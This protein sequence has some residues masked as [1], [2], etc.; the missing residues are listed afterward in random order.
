MAFWSAFLN[1]RKARQQ[2]DS[3]LPH[4]PS[5]PNAYLPTDVALGVLGGILC[6]ADKLSRLAHLRSDPAVAQVLGIENVASQSTLS[7]F[8]EAFDESAS[9]RLNSL[10]LWAI[11]RLPSLRPGYTLDLDSW[12]LLH[13]DGHQEGV[14]CGHT[15]RGLKPCHRPL[16]AC[17]AEAKLVAGF[18]LRKGNA[19]CPEQAPKFLEELLDGLPSHIR[20]SCVRADAGFY[21]EKVLQTL[22]QRRLGYVI[23]MRLYPKWQKFCRHRDSEWTPT[24]I[25]GV[26][27]QEIDSGVIG[28]RHV[29]L[30]TSLSRFPDNAGKALLEVPGYKF[31]ALVTNLPA[32]YSPVAVWRHYNGRCDSENRIKELGEQFGVKG[33]CCR[34]F[35][36]TQAICQ[37][38]I[39]AYNLCVLLQRELGLLQKIELQT[40]RW[41]LFC[42]AAVFSNAQGRPTLKLA[43]RGSAQRSWWMKVADKLSSTLPPLNCNSVSWPTEPC[44]FQSSI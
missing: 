21:H 31:R 33:F 18:W 40:L 11:A 36:S 37:L 1:K 23:V 24:E 2:L 13:R 7:R 17:L 38:A 39:W 19:Q 42:R 26:D 22:E 28:R 35:W 29:I 16:I 15:P 30:R 32:S 34:K 4:R 9:N 44:A 10:H 3:V 20:V 5:S 41:S 43:V 8:F 6:G 25:P 27:V 14:Q 12:A